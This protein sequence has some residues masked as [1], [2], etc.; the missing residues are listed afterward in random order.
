MQLTDV[1]T[2]DLMQHY[3][4][5]VLFLIASIKYLNAFKYSSGL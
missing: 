3:D 2:L 5:V 4:S 1:I